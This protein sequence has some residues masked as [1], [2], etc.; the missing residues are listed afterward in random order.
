M[1]RRP[2]KQSA[3]APEWMVTFSDMVTLLLTFFVLLLSMANMDKVK[4]QAAAESVQSAFGVVGGGSSTP[5]GKPKVVEFAPIADDFPSRLYQ[6]MLVDFNRL[7]IDKRISLVKDRGAVVLRVEESILFAPGVTTLGPEAAPALRQVAELIRNLPLH[8]R[9]EGHTDSTPA[10]AQGLSNWDLSMA[11]AINVLKFFEGEKLLA[12][13]RM[14]AV[15]Y[16]DQ[17]PLDTSGTEEGN[18]RNRR[19]EFVLESVGSN[20]EDLPYLIDSKEKLPF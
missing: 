9:I 15:G 11:R 1:A 7:Q 16:G 8:L 10:S 5:I 20:R 19:V 13:D 14:S 3:G 18:A 4:F 12:L 2:K 6:R 17:R